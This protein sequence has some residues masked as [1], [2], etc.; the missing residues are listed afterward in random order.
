MSSDYS[1]NLPKPHKFSGRDF[2]N[3]SGSTSE[4]DLAGEGRAQSFLGNLTPRQFTLRT[5]PEPKCLFLSI[6]D[7]TE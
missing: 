3:E 5:V 7:R 2:A 4:T 1:L 6:L